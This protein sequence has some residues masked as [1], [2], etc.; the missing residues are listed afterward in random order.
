MGLLSKALQM[1]DAAERPSDRPETG[2]PSAPRKDADPAAAQ[3]PDAPVHYSEPVA[4]GDDAPSPL[5]AL[6]PQPPATTTDAS[7][8]DERLAVLHQ[9]SSAVAEQFRAI[10]TSVLARWQN[11]R[12]LLHA[13]TSAQ[14]QEGKTLTVLNLGLCFAELSQRRVLVLEADL[15]RPRFAAF[16]GLPPGP[17]LA[18][19]LAQQVGIAQAAVTIPTA[20]LDV[21]AAGHP[22]GNQALQSLS[23]PAASGL[24]GELRR[25]YD[26]VLIDTPPVLPY[27][28]AGVLGALSDEI[29]L[30]TRL[31]L[32]PVSLVRQ[33]AAI[34]AGYNAPVAGLIATE[35]TRSA[36][37]LCTIQQQ[38]S[39]LVQQEK[40]A[41]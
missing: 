1:A 10:R 27:A 14:P 2:T 22:L 16:L 7:R 39:E 23:S 36:L 37:S 30:V 17:G 3:G 29:I 40:H 31:N 34:L 4:P 35:H 9:P 13:F 25:R 6:A 15:R 21:I 33:A 24:F 32:T 18:D 5:A 8:T 11:Q 38:P 28:D 20:H 41:A 26:H 12:H 19:L